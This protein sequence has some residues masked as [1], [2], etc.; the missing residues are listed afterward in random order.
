MQLEKRQKKSKKISLVRS[1]Q[2]D[3]FLADKHALYANWQHVLGGGVGG[4]G[5]RSFSFPGGRAW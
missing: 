5:V 1:C 4:P 2:G 3:F